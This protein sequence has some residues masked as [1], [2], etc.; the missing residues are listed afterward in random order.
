MRQPPISASSD[1]S[2]SA[3]KQG[4]PSPPVHEVVGLFAMPR[5]YEKMKARGVDMSW[6]ERARVKT[7]NP[8]AIPLD[9]DVC[10][11]DSIYFLKQDG[12]L[13]TIHVGGEPYRQVRESVKNLPKALYVCVKCKHYWETFVETRGHTEL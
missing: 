1:M 11:S 7:K 3:H 2:E 4:L 8:Q 5:M 9:A 12:T 13:W 10:G 6:Y